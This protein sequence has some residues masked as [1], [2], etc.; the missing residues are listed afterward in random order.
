MVHMPSR[1]RTTTTGFWAR[2]AKHTISSRYWLTHILKSQ[3]NFNSPRPLQSC[4]PLLQHVAVGSSWHECSPETMIPLMNSKHHLW[5]VQIQAFVCNLLP[6]HSSSC[7]MGS[8]CTFSVC[9][10]F[11]YTC[12]VGMRNS[13]LY[14]RWKIIERKNTG[15]LC[16]E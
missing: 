16:A 12:T 15:G 8:I 2:T 14:S 10:F 5:C 6:S 1:L 11:F 9:F 3:T 4:Q 7:I 13:K